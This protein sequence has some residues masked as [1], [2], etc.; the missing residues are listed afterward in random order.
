MPDIRELR[1]QIE[2]ELN[3]NLWTLAWQHLAQL[4]GQSP[5]ISEAIYA[6]SKFELLRDHVPLIKCRVAIERSFTIEPLIPLLRA[7]AFKGGLDLAVHVGNFNAYVQ[8][9]LE[10]E[11]ALYEFDPKI[12]ILAVQAGDAAP[13]SWERFAELSPQEVQRAAGRVGQ[14]FEDCVRAFRARSNASLIIHTLEEPPDAN[15]GGGDVGAFRKINDALHTTAKEYSGVYL[16]DYDGLITR[17]GRQGWRDESKWA[18]S[19]MP[20]ASSNL[21]HLAKEWLRFIHPLTGR[22]CKVLVTDLDNTLWGGV[23]GED[24]IEGIKCG[25]ESDGAAYQSLQRA[26][27]DL[28][29]RGVLLA[30]CSKNNEAD[31]IEAF[32]KHPGM[33]LRPR[34][35]TAI[36]INWENKAQNIR[37]LAGELKIGL[38]H[39]AYLDDDSAEIERVRA[40]LPEVTTIALPEDAAGYADVLR[41]HPVFARLAVS[42]EDKQRHRY[43]AQQRER[44]AFEQRT[45]SAE[46]FYRSLEQVAEIARLTP[47]NTNRVAQLTQKT[48]QFNLTTRRYSAQEII[49]MNSSPGWR[50]FTLCARDRFGDNG[51]V[52]VA[53]THESEQ[54][55]EIDTFLLSCRVIGRT[56][57]TALLSFL[58]ER[59]KVRGI[60]RLRGEFVPTKRN[61]VARDFYSR[62]GFQLVEENEQRWLWE[63]NPMSAAICTPEWIQLTI[64]EGALH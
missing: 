53:I 17:H 18:S 37:S 11:S 38:E 64:T 58:F 48:N 2:E 61:V 47:Q 8:E 49:E 34:D 23:I 15:A 32:E 43:Y 33:L 28:Q 21:I 52:G 9:I 4:I 27:I 59:A 25:P 40:E 41:E 56:L 1:R 24:G 63:I 31:A 57:E 35:F 60:R 19:R 5:R 36:R 45:F 14:T 16:L 50:V 13:D 22:I 44:L 10:N 20:I 51:L 29:H 7:L 12:V 30:I 46:D 55:C 54:L 26:M 3:R 62:H 39:F 6:V 42:D